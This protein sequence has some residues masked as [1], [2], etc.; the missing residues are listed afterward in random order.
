VETNWLSLFGNCLDHFSN[1]SKSLRKHDHDAFLDHA[2]VTTL[3]QI[4]V[5]NDDSLKRLI[6]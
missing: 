5:D 2:F 4:G 1:S 3:A 6:E